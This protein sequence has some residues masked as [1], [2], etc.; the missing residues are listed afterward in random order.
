MDEAGFRN[1]S[2]QKR[3][4]FTGGNSHGLFLICRRTDSNRHRPLSPRDFKA[5]N[6]LKTIR[7]YNMLP[8]VIQA[9]SSDPTLLKNR[10]QIWTF[11]IGIDSSR[12][13]SRPDRTLFRVRISPLSQPTLGLFKPPGLSNPA[14]PRDYFGCGLESGL[15]MEAA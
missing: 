14:C 4:S 11:G 9:V 5:A 13:D 2:T 12:P 3:L 7:N 15:E 6:L 8:T 10:P 1:R